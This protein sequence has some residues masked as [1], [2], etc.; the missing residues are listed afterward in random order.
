MFKGVKVYLRPIVKNDISYLNTWKNDEVTFKYLG[1][2]FSPVSIDQ[3]INWL[4]NI[5]DLT[6]PN[7]RYTI[8]TVD[9]D[10]PIGMVG[11]YGINWIHGTAEMGLY[12]GDKDQ[13]RKGFSEEAYYLLEEYA[14]KYLNLRK[15][16][17]NVVKANEKA[18][19]MWEKFGFKVVGK[20]TDE[21]YIEGKYFD[22]LIME[23]F[24][25]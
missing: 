4:D 11:L 24:M 25:R 12:I 21:R 9:K 15:L 18:K 3:Q 7:K 10:L 17:L 2:G 6:G 1:G 16:N 5:I 13:Y 19:T 23:K 20:L 8:C 14:V 22:L